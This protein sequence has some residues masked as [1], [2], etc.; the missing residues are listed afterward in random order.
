MENCLITLAKVLKKKPP[1]NQV[2]FFM[3]IIR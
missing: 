3:N 1:E 2:A